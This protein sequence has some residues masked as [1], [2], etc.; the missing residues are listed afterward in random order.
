MKTARFL[1]LAW[2]FA[3]SAFGA[4]PVNLS[5]ETNGVL[6]APTEFFTANQ[7]AITALSSGVYQP[8]DP[9]LTAFAAISGVS[10]DIIYHNGSTWVR[11]AKGTNGQ[12][13]QL[14][15]GFP[16]WATVV[17]GSGV[18]DVTLAGTNAFTGP[19]SFAGVT[20]FDGAANLNGSTTISNLTVPGVLA[21]GSITSDAPLGTSIGGTGGTNAASAR[22]SL[23]VA[24]DVDV[25][26]YRLGL[27]QAALALTADGHMLVH[28]GSLVT[29]LTST[30]AGRALLT[31]A[32]ASAQWNNYLLS[33]ASTNGAYDATSWNGIS[34]RL[35]T[36]DQFRDA[37][38]ALPG[39][40][41]AITSVTAPL[42]ISNGVL[43]I[44][45][46]G[47]GGGSGGSGWV[48][49]LT[50]SVGAW[51][52]RDASTN[53]PI[54]SKTISSN[55]L[56][57]ATGKFI[58]GGYSV[59]LSNYSGSTAALNLS[60]DVNGTTVF[61]DGYSLSSSAVAMRGLVGSLQLVRESS[62]KASLIIQGHHFNSSITPIGIGDFGSSPT[63]ASA[64]VTNITVDWTTNLV[65]SVA[66]SSD[67]TVNTNTA[68]GIQVANAWLRRESTATS[69]GSITADGT[70][71]TNIVSSASITNTVA[72]GQTTL[73]VIGSG[74]TGINADNIATGTLASNRLPSA[75]SLTTLS[76]GT[77]TA[78]SVSGDGSGLTNLNGANIASGTV[79][80][81]RIDSAIARLASP[82]LTGTPT[83]NSTN[84]MAEVNSKQGLLSNSA[85][86]AAALSDETGT[87]SAVLGTSPTID[88]PQLTGN[89][90]HTL[91][92]WSVYSGTNYV[93]DA[94]VRLL[95]LTM[96]TNIAV[97]HA[98]NRPGS[99]TTY[100]ETQL[101]I[102]GGSTNWNVVWPT[103]W[104][105]LGSN[106]TQIP[107]NKLV[108][109]AIVTQTNE[110]DTV[111]G[112]AKE[113]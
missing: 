90:V 33:V 55:D 26:A 13:L 28:N 43:S 54:F 89:S 102:L 23:G 68:L 70:A 113:E 92:S 88:S 69:G 81:A 11:L 21:V 58:E 107:S 86:L 25:Q 64:I 44:D 39:G 78:T 103:G 71:V 53:W 72:G 17:S 40:S 20:T 37:I 91:Q 94:A 61:R 12:S 97:L 2:S 45:T 100:K 5:V 49:L 87:G 24:Y 6:R 38:N 41:N 27:L 19:N 15:A 10:G 75:I 59:V 93:V 46:S 50:N 1:L 76:A 108:W 96:S 52:G 98:T 48:Y 73:S 3:L 34:D 83:I 110:T 82:A 101:R 74:V 42:S 85:G 77:L 36:L 109:V 57:T 4:A 29:N 9:D 67:S 60:A 79:A 18:G 14:S 62:T 80:A 99:S 7:S 32:S 31:A 30:A 95:T 84:L 51:Q 112:I 105:R 104:R 63:E 106:I 47:L 8:A 22:A 66:V 65:L 111:F 16:T 56:P 35:V